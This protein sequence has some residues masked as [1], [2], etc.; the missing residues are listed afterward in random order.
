LARAI[1]PVA[2]NL[3]RV[4]RTAAAETV[5]LD[6][7]A[8]APLRPEAA[9][10]WQRWATH[11]GN[12]S[13]S[14]RD[15]RTARRVLDDARDTFA[16]LLGCDPGAVVFTSGGTEADDL[17]VQGVLDAAAPGA[18]AVCSAVEH[19][20]VLDPV[21][22]RGGMTVPV[23]RDGVVRPDVLA[24]GLRSAAAAGPVAVVSI[25]AVNNETGVRQP[26]EDLV[27]VVREHAP[28]AVVHVDAVAAFC[29][30]DV[31]RTTASADLVTVSAHKFGGPQG[32]GVL[33]VRDGVR[34]AAR[35]VG[36]TQERGRRA[37]TPN[38]AGIA[39]AAAAASAT[40]ADRTDTVA[41]VEGLRDRLAA[42]VLAVPGV[43][44]TL[45]PMAER[46]A[47]TLHVCVRGVDSEPLL[48]LLDEGGVRASAGSSC[49]SGAR[50]RSHVV[51]AMGVDPD[52][53]RGALRFSLGHGTTTADCD[54]AVEVF[55][56]AV[57]RLREV[58]P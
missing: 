21:L 33:V 25:L 53:G 14:H 41:R 15:A 9:Q 10:A 42:G 47:G 2:G 5:Y 29:W 16:E 4:T 55:A 8:T 48:F 20:A 52:L 35:L 44:P 17:A 30:T 12:P 11:V 38:V 23:D 24:E 28:G 51:D 39:A 58:A 57:D 22:A 18:F 27:A 31:A 3:T 7:S 37:G 43:V 56:A 19:H 36:G 46:V 13:G 45:G 40:A 32:V 49:Q 50:R 26:V 34:L 54:R 1:V 6:W